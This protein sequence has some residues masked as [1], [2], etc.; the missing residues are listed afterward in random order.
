VAVVKKLTGRQTKWAS[1]ECNDKVY[2]EFAI[3]KGN[4]D[5]IRKELF[6]TE[7]GY[8]RNCGVHDKEWQADHILPVFKGGGACGMDNFQTLCLDCH[9]EKTNYQRDSHRKANSSHAS[10]SSLTFLL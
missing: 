9:H 5:I 8:C 7:Q 3:L 2:L 4:T 10:L 6:N 1:R